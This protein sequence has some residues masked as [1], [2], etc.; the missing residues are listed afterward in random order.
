MGYSQ[1]FVVEKFLEG[2]TN[3]RASNFFSKGDAL[4][5]FGEHFELAIRRA[6][7]DNL[8]NKKEW[9]LLNGDKYSIT[10]S[11]HQGVTFPPLR[12]NL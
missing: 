1:S 9:F 4:Y 5:S 7:E 10:T 2:I 12:I 6:K 3:K 11:Q 8:Q